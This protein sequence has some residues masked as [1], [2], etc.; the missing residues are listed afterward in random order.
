MHF[1]DNA[2]IKTEGKAYDKVLEDAGWTSEDG[3][4]AYT[5][6]YEE[7]IRQSTPDE[8]GKYTQITITATQTELD[9]SIAEVDPNI[10]YD[11]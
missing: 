6:T 7:S 4:T 2:S 10:S 5:E 1:N 3:W 11:F 8:D 9:L